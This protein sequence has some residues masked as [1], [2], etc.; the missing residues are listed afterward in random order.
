MS[1]R[2]TNVGLETGRFIIETALC[3]AEIRAI[4]RKGPVA[5]G[6]ASRIE[7]ELFTPITGPI[8][9]NITIRTELET[10]QIPVS[11]TVVDTG[12]RRS[13]HVKVV[14]RGQRAASPGR[15]VSI[16]TQTA[17]MEKIQ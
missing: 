1:L 8:N 5:P 16:S 9:T 6:L 13:R 14:C 2:I 17:L 3:D 15:P 10:L 4:H 7:V 11:A 12:A